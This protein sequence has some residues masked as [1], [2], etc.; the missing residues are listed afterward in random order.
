[1]KKRSKNRTTIKE[2][3]AK[4]KIKR[5]ARKVTKCRIKR[6]RTKDWKRKTG[7][8]VR[9]LFDVKKL[10]H[11]VSVILID[12]FLFQIKHFVM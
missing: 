1:M 2:A 10:K 6:D 8:K 9:I 7:T 3:K 11:S 12:F 4:K 5:I